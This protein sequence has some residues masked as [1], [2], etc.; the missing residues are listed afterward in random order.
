METVDREVRRIIIMVAKISLIP[1]AGMAFAGNWA[2]VKGFILGLCTSFLGFIMMAQKAWQITGLDSQ[3][4]G[5]R[6]AVGNYFVRLT[7]YGAVLALAAHKA[8]I[9]FP[10]AAVGLVML[11]FTLVGAGILKNIKDIVTV[12]FGIFKE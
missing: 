4:E 2:G 10:A 5:R 1:L 9:S 12:K 7:L 6:L 3:E 11:K 8:A